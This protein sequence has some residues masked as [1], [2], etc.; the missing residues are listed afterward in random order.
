LIVAYISREPPPPIV[1][2]PSSREVARRKAKAE[3]EARNAAAAR[4]LQASVQRAYRPAPG[5]VFSVDIAGLL[6]LG[7]AGALGTSSKMA[8]TLAPLAAGGRHPITVLMAAGG[9]ADEQALR[10]ALA[11]IVPKLGALG[12]LINRRKAGLRMAKARP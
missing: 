7:P 4:Q 10:E 3:A 9:W 6:L 2:P 1:Y 5:E 8:A 11:A 12:L